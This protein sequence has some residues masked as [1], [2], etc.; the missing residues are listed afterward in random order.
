MTNL[1][2]L[3][4]VIR[5]SY[6][7]IYGQIRSQKIVISQS[8]QSHLETIHSHFVILQNQKKSLL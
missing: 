5:Q 3:S 2:S 7:V 8:D 1:W 6:Q 4:Q